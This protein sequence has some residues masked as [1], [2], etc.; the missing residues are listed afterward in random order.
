MLVSLGSAA[1]AATTGMD[2]EEEE[3]VVAVRVVACCFVCFISLALT[4]FTWQGD[5]SNVVDVDGGIDDED[6]YV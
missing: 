3:V 6:I 4:F 5:D 2:K 1:A